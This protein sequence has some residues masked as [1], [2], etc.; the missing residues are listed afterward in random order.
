VLSPQGP[1]HDNI[2][3]FIPADPWYRGASVRSESTMDNIL[4]P[5]IYKLMKNKVI[6]ETLNKI[7]SI[8]EACAAEKA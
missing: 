3:I 8:L 5:L 1:E 6:V 2:S 4:K 7:K